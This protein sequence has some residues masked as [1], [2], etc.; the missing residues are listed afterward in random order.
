MEGDGPEAFNYMQPDQLDP[1]RRGPL[2]HASW[3]TTCPLTASSHSRP[4]PPPRPSDGSP[5]P[6]EVV[7]L[8]LGCP[9]A[10][11][12]SCCQRSG[13]RRWRGP[14]DAQLPMLV[15]ASGRELDRMRGFERGADDYSSSRSAPGAAGQ[16]RRAATAL[17]GAAQ[18]GR[19]RVGTLEMEP[20]SRDTWVDGTPLHLTN[21]GSRS[22]C[23]WP[24]SPHACSRARSSCA[25]VWGFRSPGATRTRTPTLA[26]PKARAAP[27]G[28]W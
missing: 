14:M 26:A 10:T 21:K 11:G 19:M 5:P 3:P 15:L 6:P 16:A 13:N 28:T 24:P 18:A 12:W 9:I 23:C 8:D 7:D 25:D 2:R 22:P 17:P 4:R 20:M 1:D 27:D